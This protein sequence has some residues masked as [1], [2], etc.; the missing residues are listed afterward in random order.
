MSPQSTPPS[1]PNF[2]RMLQQ[3]P[4]DDVNVEYLKNVLLSFMEHKDRRVSVSP[5]S[6]VSH[7]IWIYLHALFIDLTHSIASWVDYNDF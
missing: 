2:G 5:S 1:T 4:E 3:H 7:S 6:F